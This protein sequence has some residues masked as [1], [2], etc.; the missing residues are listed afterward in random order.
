M[1]E[2]KAEKLLRKQFL[3]EK[4]VRQL[5]SY[6]TEN[7][8]K[9]AKEN[10]IILEFLRMAFYYELVSRSRSGRR[11][12]ERKIEQEDEPLTFYWALPLPR[13]RISPDLV[14]PKR[15]VHGLTRTRTLLELKDM[16]LIGDRSFKEAARKLKNLTIVEEGGLIASL[17]ES[18]ISFATEP[19]GRV[20][21]PK[22][23][24]RR[25]T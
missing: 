15:S 12:I 3:T 7:S 21:K 18:E 6:A 17:F 24:V 25:Q 2:K 8:N 23:R 14:H 10:L 11:T 13:Q 9:L 20:G 16:G 5:I 22:V 1:I 4:G 19:S